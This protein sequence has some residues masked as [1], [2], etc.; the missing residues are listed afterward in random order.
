MRSV[1]F[2]AVSPMKLFALRIDWQSLRCLPLSEVSAGLPTERLARM[3]RFFKMEDSYRCAIAGHL[4]NF[5]F[6]QL[7]PDEPRP[8]LIE[9]PRGKPAFACSTAP[10][11]NISHSGDW[12]IGIAGDGPLGVDVEE[13]KPGYALLIDVLSSREFQTLEKMSESKRTTQFIRLWTLKEA[14]LKALGLGLNGMPRT[15]SFR[16][17]EDE[18]ARLEEQTSDPFSHHTFLLDNYYNRHVPKHAVEAYGSFIRQALSKCPEEAEAYAKHLG[19]VWR[20][21]GVTRPQYSL[22]IFL[23]FYPALSQD[24]LFY[25]KLLM[26]T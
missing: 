19:T 1:V 24:Q 13:I 5:L 9:G 6:E 10:E 17:N 11:F 20:V 3:N 12:V 26:S 18:I 2:S 4:V 15:L 8:G 21:L 23:L 14:Y 16:L 22:L 25:R 7:R